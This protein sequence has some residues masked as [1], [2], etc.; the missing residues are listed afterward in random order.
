MTSP[1]L[2][3][4][5]SVHESAKSQGLLLGY[6]ETLYVKQAR[7]VFTNV[8]VLDAAI[9]A[10]R[11]DQGD[12]PYS[13]S[14]YFACAGTECATPGMI[15]PGTENGK[16]MDADSYVALILAISSRKLSTSSSFSA[17]IFCD[18]DSKASVAPCSLPDALPSIA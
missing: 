18:D 13:L 15:R 8:S 1:T 9:K 4:F 3:T 10:L 16:G 7:S 5:P 6:W 11:V 17:F 2:Q 14:K 12:G